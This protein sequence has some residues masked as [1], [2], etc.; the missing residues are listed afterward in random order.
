[1]LA[2]EF[3]TLSAPDINLKN[4]SHF[5]KQTVGNLNNAIAEVVWFYS[6]IFKIHR[7]FGTIVVRLLFL[8]RKTMA[9]V[10]LIPT[11]NSFK[12]LIQVPYRLKRD[13]FNFFFRLLILNGYFTLTESW[14]LIN[15]IFEKETK[16]G[17]KISLF[18]YQRG[19]I[20]RFYCGVTHQLQLLREDWF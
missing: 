17:K 7:Y 14:K 11:L 19:F 9:G 13:L 2:S 10:L 6:N 12:N 18:D 8:C 3:S 16:N 20:L 4:V 15:R 1:M 5:Q